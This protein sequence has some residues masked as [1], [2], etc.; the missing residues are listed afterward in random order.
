M[1]RPKSAMSYTED[2]DQI[3][4]DFLDLV[5]DSINENNEV[6]D[7]LELVNMYAL[8]SIVIIFLDKRLGALKKNLPKNSEAKVGINK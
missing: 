4:S 7:L 6:D 3:A 1:L 8:E 5:K 2:I